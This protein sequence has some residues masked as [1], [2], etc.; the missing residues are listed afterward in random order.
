M[1]SK[2]GERKSTAEN[3]KAQTMSRA[4]ITAAPKLPILTTKIPPFDT[5]Q[6]FSVTSPLFSMPTVIFRGA[7]IY[8]P[9]LASQFHSKLVGE[10][11]ADLIGGCYYPILEATCSR[12][13]ASGQREFSE[14]TVEHSDRVRRYQSIVI[15][16]TFQTSGSDE[17]DCCLEISP[18]A[19]KQPRGS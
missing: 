16:L 2:T 5:S 19:N 11:V 9:N 3:Q 1:G 10:G 6:R 18:I 17:S 8:D 4:R 14:Y 15:P 12:V 13:L 7:W